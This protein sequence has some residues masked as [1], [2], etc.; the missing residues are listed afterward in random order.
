[1][2]EETVPQMRETIDRIR[3]ERN[4]ALKQ[5]DKLEVEI[6][7]RDAREAF[8][9]GGYDS[10]HGDLF[11]AKNPDMEINE[12]NVATFA[13]EWNLAAVESSST[14]EGEG[15]EPSKVDDGSE[16]LAGMAGSGTSTGEGGSDG[17]TETKMTRPDWA[18]LMISDPAKAKAVA[19]SGQVELSDD[20]PWLGSDRVRTLPG[21]NPYSTLPE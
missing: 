18:K 11:A 4:S 21:Q 17:A 7:V 9:T 12:E 14:P 5:V 15:E 20:N 13:D 3:G 1:M 10:R 8:R 6:H 16:A 19:V 2:S